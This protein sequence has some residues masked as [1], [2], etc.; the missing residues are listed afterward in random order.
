[1]SP[2]T[3]PANLVPALEATPLPGPEW[4]FHVLLVFTFVLHVLF[5]NL[6]LGGTVLAAISQ[7]FS[8]GQEGDHRTV[9]AQ[10]LMGVNVY[11]ISLTITT[12]IAPLLFVQV[13]FQQYFYTATILISWIWFGFLVLLL[14]GYYSTYGVGF[15]SKPFDYQEVLDALNN[16]WQS[17]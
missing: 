12:G 8:K 4:L 2:E 17:S 13:I 1:M 7:V 11:A 5:M 10:R 3:V 15:I 6:T 16:L 14:L 9:L